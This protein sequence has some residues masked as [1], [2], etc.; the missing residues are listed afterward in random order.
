M[1]F[2]IKNIAKRGFTCRVTWRRLTWRTGQGDVAR[3]TNPGCDVALRPRGSARVARAGGTQGAAKWQV[4]HAATW[5]PVW[6]DT[7][8]W[9]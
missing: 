4:G 1:E 5:A 9:I 7:C 8:G 2:I 6:G 3:G